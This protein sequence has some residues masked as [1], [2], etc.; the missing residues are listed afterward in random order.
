MLRRIGLLLLLALTLAACDSGSLVES[1]AP[2]EA[3]DFA[4]HYLSLF[5]TR[6]FAG[7]EAKLDPGLK[8]AQL[9]PALEKIADALPK[10]NTVKAQAIGWEFNDTNGVRTE[11][12]KFAYWYPVR[13]VLAT[14]TFNKRDEAVVVTS[15]QLAPLTGTAS[16]ASGPTFSHM[17]PEKYAFV[18]MAVAIPL[19]ILFS[20]V[21]CIRT[22]M[23]RWKWLWIPSMLVG[24]VTVNLNWDT[25]DIVVAPLQF[26]LFGVGWFAD[27]S[28]NVLSLGLPIGAI[29]F[30]VLRGY[31][32]R[33]A[34]R[35][36]L[37][38]F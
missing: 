12:F 15:V 17:T 38:Q 20:I 28:A 7:I 10:D 18:V 26:I 33:K 5:Q 23:S 24:I 25:G 8:N 13:P 21:I 6:D 3:L 2:K 19:F 16:S 4:R 14:I 31:W 37:Q 36:T 29:L 30:L 1:V 32:R 27:A 9:R 11:T 34:Q 35:E 22:K